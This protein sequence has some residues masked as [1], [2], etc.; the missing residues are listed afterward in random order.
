MNKKKLTIAIPTYNRVTTLKKCLDQLLEQPG[1]NKTEILVSDN[2][3]TD[4]TQEFMQEYAKEHSMV[5]YHRNSENI[6]PDRNFL[7]C[8]E[9]ATSEYVYLLSD[10]DIL[11]PD[12]LE[13]ILEAL[14]NNPVFVHLNSCS[15][16]DEE[17]K[18]YSL[19][20]YK[21]EGNLEFSDRTEFFKKIGIRITF[22]SAL[23]MKK[24][25][26]DEIQNKESY[27]GSYFLQSHLAIKCLA[28]KGTY[29]LVTRNC[30]AASPN[31]TVGYDLYNVWIK[32]LHELLVDTA[33]ESG[34]S[35]NDARYVFKKELNKTVENF[36]ISFRL[37]NENEKEW[38]RQAA[39]DTLKQYPLLFVKFMILIY[40][41][42]WLLKVFNNIKLI[43]REAKKIVKGILLYS[44]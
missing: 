8:Y 19:P 13:T 35:I 6:G 42:H 4:S 44:K 9:L 26:L 41:P 14:D 34:I 32:H 36:V 24:S 5:Q 12:V 39:I 20:R 1:I 33:V 11:L 10:D 16:L 28:S 23:I 43:L 40:S 38:N 37:R 15:L 18:I 21:E 2:A 22:L 25:I 27:I 31:E 7:K 3:S 17:K 29:V 30:L